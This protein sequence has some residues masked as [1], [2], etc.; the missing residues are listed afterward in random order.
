LYFNDIP[1]RGD[2]ARFVE[3]NVTVKNQ[4]KEQTTI[5]SDEIKLLAQNGTEYSTDATNEIWVNPAGQS[6]SL[7]RLTLKYPKQRISFSLS[8]KM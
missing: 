3:L 6:F 8:L 4:K 1:S 7:N 2:G 5:S